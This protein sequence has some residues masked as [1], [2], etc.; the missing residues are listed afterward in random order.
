[1]KR[2]I[3]TCRLVCCFLWGVYLAPYVYMYD[4]RPQF[5]EKFEGRFLCQGAYEGRSIFESLDMAWGAN[6]RVPGVVRWSKAVPDA[7]LLRAFPKDMLKKVGGG[8]ESA[9]CVLV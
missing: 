4:L 7:G 2:T 1:M 5:T 9:C 8:R 6:S 3:C